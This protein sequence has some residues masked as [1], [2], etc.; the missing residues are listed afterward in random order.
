MQLDSLE[1][2][3]VDFGTFYHPLQGLAETL[4]QHRSAGL[5]DGRQTFQ[6]P[7]TRMA[8]LQLGHQETIRQEDHVHVAGLATATPKLTFTHAQML[9]AIPMEAFCACPTIAIYTKNTSH[10]PSRPVRDQSLSGFGIVTFVPENHHTD[11]VIHLGD[12]NTDGKVP[13]ASVTSLHELA[14]FGI[15]LRD[16]ILDLEFFAFKEDL[17]VELQITDIVSLQAIDIVQVVLVSEPTVK[18][19]VTGDLVGYAPAHY[20]L[21]M[22]C[23][24]VRTAPSW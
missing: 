5:S 24:F 19:E 14:I 16:H 18:G 1:T 6:C 2:P 7:R 11:F 8:L 23:P 10:L 4:L 12:T 22:Q 15:N 3:A 13:L 9:L 21:G 20:D 17:T